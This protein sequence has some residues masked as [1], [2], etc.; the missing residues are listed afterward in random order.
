MG[1]RIPPEQEHEFGRESFRRVENRGEPEPEG[2][3]DAEDLGNVPHKDVQA[4]DEPG[5]SERKEHEAEK[6]NRHQQDEHADFAQRDRRMPSRIANPIR[7]L[8]TPAS[9]TVSGRISVGK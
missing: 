2:Q 9:I 8:T 5:Q 4:G 3:D 1:Q 6:I 7:W